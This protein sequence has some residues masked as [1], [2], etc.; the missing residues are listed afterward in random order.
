[1]SMSWRKVGEKFVVCKDGT[2]FAM[3]KE[4]V[5]EMTAITA[6][7]MTGSEKYYQK[8]A[9]QPCDKGLYVANVLVGNMEIDPRAPGPARLYEAD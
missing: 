6:D 8:D 2:Y 7:I 5:S 4:Q 3:T 1:M 9:R